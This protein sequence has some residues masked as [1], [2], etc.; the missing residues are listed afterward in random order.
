V[1]TDGIKIKTVQTACIRVTD[2]HINTFVESAPESQLWSLWRRGRL[3]LPAGLA[4]ALVAQ[5]VGGVGARAAVG[6]G[7]GGAWRQHLAAGGPAVR[8]LA[9]AGEAP[10][11]VHTAAPVQT[12]AGRTLVDVHLAQVT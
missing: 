4:G 9:H 2:Q 6:A 8:Q 5:V 1:Q 10:H 11:A 7:V 3:T 12:G